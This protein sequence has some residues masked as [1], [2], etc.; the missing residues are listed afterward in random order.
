M[1]KHTKRNHVEYLDGLVTPHRRETPPIRTPTHAAQSVVRMSPKLLDKLDSVRH[2]LPELDNPIHRARDQEIR[3]R[4]HRHKRQL[5]LVHQRLG[6]PR[7][8]RQRIHVDFLKRQ[9]SSLFLGSVCRRHRRA[10]VIVGRVILYYGI[11]AVSR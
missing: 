1:G 6:V 4:G 8:C 7:R 10:E 9:L 11:P 2:L 3:V 5:V